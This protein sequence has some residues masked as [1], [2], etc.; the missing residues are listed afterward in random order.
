MS[1]L[2]FY[3]HRHLLHFIFPKCKLNNTQTYLASVSKF[4]L[5]SISK[6]N[7]QC[8]LNIREPCF[9]TKIGTVPDYCVTHNLRQKNMMDQLQRCIND[10]S[11]YVQNKYGIFW[12][13][14][15]DVRLFEDLIA[16]H[17]L[18]IIVDTCHINGKGCTIV[19]P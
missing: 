16:K 17:N 2:D 14:N 4:W 13:N 11:Y 19:I 12:E 5:N 15:K 18:N 3:L 7:Y 9:I 6:Y 8:V 1:K 10:E